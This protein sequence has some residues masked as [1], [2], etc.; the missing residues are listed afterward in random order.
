MKQF[1]TF[2][3]ILAN[4]IV[5]AQIPENYYAS[6]YGKK[7]KSLQIALFQIIDEHHTQSY[8]GLWS[9]FY[10]TDVKPDGT[11]WD[12]YSDVPDGTPPYTYEFS[13]DQCG[14][15]SGEGDCYNREH[16]MPKSWFDD[17]MPMYTDLFHL[18]PTDGYVNGKRGNFPYGEVGSATWT[19]EN[20][21][22]LGSCSYPGY[23]GTVFEPIDEYKGDLARTYLYMCTRYMDKSLDI[24]NGATMLEDSQF[25]PWALEMLIRWHEQDAV[26]QKE[27]DRNNAIHAIQKN[28]NPFIDHPELVGKIFGM[29]SI[30][31]FNPAGIAHYEKKNFSIAPNPATESIVI[32]SANA[33]DAQIRILDVQGR[34]MLSCAWSNE[35]ELSVDLSRFQSGFYI[36]LVNS[37]NGKEIHKLV[38]L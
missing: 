29:D 35:N 23:N 32:R 30:N 19:S 18:Y 38:K 14:N 6:A 25:K 11:V 31:G 37:K 4:G 20:G 9:C 16:S 34:E 8:S 12:I 21:S 33:V 2:L 5:Q 13:V 1:I 26:S 24:E 17:D 28:R 22:K 15:Y 3:L 27:I 36:I 10:T 7:G